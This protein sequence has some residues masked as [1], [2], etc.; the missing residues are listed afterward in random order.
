M[1]VKLATRDRYHLSGRPTN[2][3]FFLT[4][5]VKSLISEAYTQHFTVEQMHGRP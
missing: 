5:M 2:T 1:I 4:P 3:I